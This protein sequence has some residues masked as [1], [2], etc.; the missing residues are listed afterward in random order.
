M[1]N[2][3]LLNLKKSMKKWFD[4]LITRTKRSIN[5]D[6][7]AHLYKWSKNFQEHLEHFVSEQKNH[8]K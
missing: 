1:I 5:R 2:Q 4:P 8:F 3:H 7:N 6:P